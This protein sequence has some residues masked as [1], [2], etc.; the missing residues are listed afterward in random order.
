[1]QRRAIRLSPQCGDT[2][3]CIIH[4]VS[5]RLLPLISKENVHNVRY[6]IVYYLKNNKQ[7]IITLRPNNY[8][9]LSGEGQAR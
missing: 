8:N 6:K 4:L 3:S 5:E 1:M 2:T 7:V 9:V